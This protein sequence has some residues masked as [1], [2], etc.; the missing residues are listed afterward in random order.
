MKKKP[1]YSSWV[2][3][4][5]NGLIHFQT[6]GCEPMAKSNLALTK[7]FCSDLGLPFVHWGGQS[8]TPSKPFSPVIGGWMKKR[9]GSSVSQ[10]IDITSSVAGSNTSLSPAMT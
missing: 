1:E 7:S 10:G 5:S 2:G 9:K 6:S 8:P 4:K 3:P